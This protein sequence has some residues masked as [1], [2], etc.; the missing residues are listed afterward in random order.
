VTDKQLSDKEF[1]ALIV[2][3]LS[4]LPS[5]APSRHF[6]DKVMNRVQLA[7]PRPVVAWR[8]ARSWVAQP[9]RALALAGA[10]VC[11]A[12]I[13]LVV[14][15]PWLMRH[16]PSI[17]FG[18]DWLLARGTSVIRDVAM[19]VASWTITSGISG[20]VKSIPLSGPQLWALALGAT[21]TYAGCAIGLHYLLRAPRD[22]NA[23]VQVQA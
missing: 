21:A 20:L 4:S 3:S 6:A 13:A 1:D 15:V 11:F 16:S 23:P 7:S 9:R 12:S 17:R 10:Y 22:K 14:A 18:A 5:Y 8:R 19:A 2:R